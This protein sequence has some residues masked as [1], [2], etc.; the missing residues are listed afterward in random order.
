MITPGGY[1]PSQHAYRQ[2]GLLLGP[3]NLLEN[4]VPH[5]NS[6]ADS[7]C[8]VPQLIT[9]IKDRRCLVDS[10]LHKA[11]RFHRMLADI[12]LYAVVDNEVGLLG[13]REYAIRLL[14]QPGLP[15]AQAHAPVLVPPQVVR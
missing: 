13:V 12:P 11:S 15:E 7:V 6:W 5:V 8:A 14:E 10:F 1:Y 4:M 3:N 2:E 9:R